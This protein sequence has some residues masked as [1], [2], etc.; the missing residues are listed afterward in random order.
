MRH[1]R[2]A[3][4]AALLV[5]TFTSTGQGQTRA[6][7]DG[8]GRLTMHGTPRFMLGVYDSGG[9]YSA[10]PALWEQQIFSATGPRGLQGFPLNLY[11]NYWMGGMPIDATNAL[12]DTL[13]AH[14]LM[15]LQ[16]GNCFD[17]GSWTRYGPGSFSIMS[18][19]Y[20]QQFA[21]HPAAAGYYVMDE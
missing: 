15:Y 1:L 18:Q 14:G 10:D 17:T 16:T 8:A 9:S 19:A 5:A 11:L 21:L 3:V 2:S 12:L 13:N 4:V 20:V 7:F 6:G